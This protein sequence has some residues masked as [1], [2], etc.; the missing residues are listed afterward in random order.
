MDEPFSALDPLIRTHLQDELLELQ[1][2][3]QKT[4]IFVSHDLE[5]A[6]KLGTHI[7]IMKSGKIVQYGTP[8]E[9]LLSPAS[10]YVEAFVS[11]L[12]P[13]HLLRGRS[14]MTPL[15]QLRREG[16]AY[17]LDRWGRYRL[18]LNEAGHPTVRLEGENVPLRPYEEGVRLSKDV[19]GIMLLAQPDLT[20]QSLIE[21]LRASG[22]PVLVKSGES[23]LGVVGEEEIY[24]GFLHTHHLKQARS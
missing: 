21:S 12:N 16:Q 19:Q 17:V 2:S 18:T 13:I 1:T 20:M 22:M 8:E 4:I 9:I 7:G 11:H 3:L 15:E 6:V 10:N 5:E 23:V 14:L 24:R